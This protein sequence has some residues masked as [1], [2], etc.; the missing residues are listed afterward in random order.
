MAASASSASNP[1]VDD[2]FVDLLLYEHLDA[3][4]LTS[5]P[6]FADHSRETFD[7]YLGAVRRF[8]R[9][10]LFA[11]YKPMDLEPPVLRDGQVITHP[12]LPR[13]FRSMVELGVL[14]ATRPEEVG[15]QQLPH[16]VATLATAYLMAANLSAY[17]YVG[18]THGAA[19]L[20]EAFGSD[21]LKDAY[22]K[23]MYAGDW[24]GTMALTEPHAGSSLG[25]VTTRAMP[26]DRGHHLIRGS[27]IFISGADHTMVDNV[28]HL[29]LARIDGA[30]AGSKGIS[31][32]AVPKRRW[33]DGQLV[34][35]DVR[36]SQVIHKIGWRGLP[37]TALEYGDDGDCHGYL[38]GEENQGLRY[39]FQ[40][41][42][43]ARL[44]VGM[45]GAA[46]ASVAYHEARLYALSRP[47]GRGLGQLPSSPIVPIIEHADVRRMLIRQ[48]AFVEGSLAVLATTARYADVA[49]H[50]VSE[51]ERE[52][53]QVLLDLLT[54]IAKTFPAERGFEANALAVQV[55]GGYG[56]TSEYLPESYL[57]D[58]R[59]NSIHEG[60]TGI[61]S[62]DLV[63]RKLGAKGGA[64]LTA[65]AEEVRKTLADAEAHAVPAAL[66]TALRDA[67]GTVSALVPELLGRGMRGDAAGMLSHSADFLD[68]LGTLVVGWQW[69]ALYV[70][71]QRSTA[72]GATQH[73]ARDEGL[74]CTAQYFLTTELPRVALLAA[75]CRSAEDSYVKMRPEWFG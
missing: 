63:G 39:M 49:Q 75:L 2:A 53:A 13:L 46:T 33:Q 71:A 57:R 52:R 64:G 11:T 31:L 68:L 47:Q 5:L 42:N 48:K 62:L 73:A 18:L 28:V 30:P 4:G 34:P 56:Y 15:G 65:L 74:R 19:H 21:A 22:M 66:V 55:L 26:T 70:V 58:Q 9:E 35:N 32:F 37:S 72:A 69:L 7:L 16:V 14:T 23:P 27:K 24:N 40:M 51:A 43:E 8:A 12:T 59:L 3:A 54:P 45:N 44:M 38:V 60:T 20:I 6:A 41:M 50:G 36:V 25:D 61:Q 67:A 10:E 17:G 1:L 29:T